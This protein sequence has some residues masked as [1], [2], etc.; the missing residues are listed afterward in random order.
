MGQLDKLALA[1][2]R[3]GLDH[4]QST[5]DELGYVVFPASRLAPHCSLDAE[6]RPRPREYHHV[7][8]HFVE[9]SCSHASAHASV[10]TETGRI[11]GTFALP[12]AAGVYVSVN[13]VICI[14]A[15]SGAQ[16]GVVSDQSRGAGVL[17]G[18]NSPSGAEHLATRF[19]RITG[20]ATPPPV[21]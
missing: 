6:T 12:N 14:G 17:G 3:D 21:R 13:V 5:I 8:V 11:A 10:Q 16:S 1:A 9:E 18:S 7:A 2:Q 19:T 15:F 20:K 4:L